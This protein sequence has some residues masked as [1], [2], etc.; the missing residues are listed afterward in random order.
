LAFDYLM[1]YLGPE[2]F[3][4]AMRFYFEQWKFE[5]PTPEDLIKTLQYYLN[6]DLHWFVEEMI[7]TNKKLD[8]KMVSH[9]QLVDHSHAI[10][11][12]TTINY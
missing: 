6:A 5:H 12:K 8:Y 2:K 10:L 11:V 3:D 1:N 7:V 9:K 4:E